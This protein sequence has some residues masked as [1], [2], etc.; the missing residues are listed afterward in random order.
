[1]PEITVKERGPLGFAVAAI[2]NFLILLL[3]S[4]HATW[5]PWLG[6]IVTDAFADVLWA[7]NLTCMVQIIGNLILYVRSP[8]WLR[9]LMDVVFAVAALI[10]AIVLYRVFP[11]DL[12]RFGELVVV[13]AHVL[14]F[15]GIFGTSVAIFVNLVRLASGSGSSHPTTHAHP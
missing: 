5:R 12:E 14:L 11:F 1:M 7:V 10:G 2:F 8:W 13:L 6:G 9:R 15:F 4:A 3:A